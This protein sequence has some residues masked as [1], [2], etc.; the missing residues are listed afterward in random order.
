MIPV[1]LCGN[2]YEEP[3]TDTFLN[4]LNRFGGI[5]YYGKKEFLQT[6]EEP[7]F[8]VFSSFEVPKIT[9]NKGILILKNGAI[10]PVRQVLS[11]NWIAVIDSQNENVGKILKGTGVTAVSCGMSARDTLSISSISEGTAMISLQRTIKTLQNMIVE[12]RDI[13]VDFMQELSPF[14]LLSA[15]AVLLFSGEDGGEGHRFIFEKIGSYK[16]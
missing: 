12:P 13:E 1:F 10:P 14:L 6:N 8:S 9:A 5:Q 11:N 2:E 16:S 3:S 7:R 4:L 15:C